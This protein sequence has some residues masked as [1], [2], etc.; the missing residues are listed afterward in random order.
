M[1]QSAV[2][3]LRALANITEEELNNAKNLLK[4]KFYAHLQDPSLRLEDAAKLLALLKSPTIN[5]S[6][7]IDRVTVSQVEEAVRKALKS[8][9]VI[10]VNGGD[11]SSLGSYD[12]LA[13]KFA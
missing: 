6:E 8:R 12:S 9:P 13:S 2:E 4:V 1:I 10:Y 5:F 7:H 11:A 3:E